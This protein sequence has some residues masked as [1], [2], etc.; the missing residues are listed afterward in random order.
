M[1]GSRG[2][3]MQNAINY[4]RTTMYDH[5]AY[6]SFR[7]ETDADIIRGAESFVRK[8][9]ELNQ[10][11]VEQGE[12]VNPIASSLNQIAGN[13]P[14]EGVPAGIRGVESTDLFKLFN[15]MR[16]NS[17]EERRERDDMYEPNYDPNVQA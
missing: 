13:T 7:D 1:E 8:R 17:A 15:A 9:R 11:L 4:L 6:N 5:A 14:T 12:R 10:R 16:Q 2:E 3:I